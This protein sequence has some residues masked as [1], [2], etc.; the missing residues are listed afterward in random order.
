M[1]TITHNGVKLAYDS[2]GKGKPAFV[3]IHGWT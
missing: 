2:R 1:P 3:F